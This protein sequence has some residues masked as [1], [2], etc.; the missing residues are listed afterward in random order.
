MVD[1]GKWVS[2]SQKPD[3]GLCSRGYSV[4]P[5]NF[6]VFASFRCER[7]R[8]SP[9]LFGEQIGS[10]AHYS[11]RIM[12][13]VCD[14]WLLRWFSSC[15][16]GKHSDNGSLNAGDFPD[17]NPFPILTF[18]FTPIDIILVSRSKLG[19][20]TILRCVLT[21]KNLVV[22]LG[23]TWLCDIEH[24]VVMQKVVVRPTSTHPQFFL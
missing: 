8:V 9:G 24:V 5:A 17:A 19:L 22:Q 2:L 12:F 23:T 20:L 4:L 15:V 13:R 14:C 11:V 18:P 16:V 21:D 6:S 1:V 3:F 7:N 10:R